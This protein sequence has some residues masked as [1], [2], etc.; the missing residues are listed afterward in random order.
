MADEDPV[1]QRLHARREVGGIVTVIGEGRTTIDDEGA[2]ALTAD[3]IV[4]ADHRHPV[5]ALQLVERG[6][7]VAM[8]AQ[9]IGTR[10]AG[11]GGDPAVECQI[12]GGDAGD[13]VAGHRHR[14]DEVRE[15]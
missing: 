4:D 7:N 3:P 15:L 10:H 12:A 8:F 11:G 13:I 14:P 9:V 2:A 6:E 5:L 1:E